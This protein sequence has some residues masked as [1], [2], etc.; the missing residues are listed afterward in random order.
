MVAIQWN[1]LSPS[2]NA[3]T[4]ESPDILCVCVWG[5]G[6]MLLVKVGR[7][8]CCGSDPHHECHQV[9]LQPLG[10]RVSI[11]L[12]RHRGV[13][14]LLGRGVCWGSNILRCHLSK[15]HRHTRQFE[16]WN[17]NWTCARVQ[18]KAQ[19]APW[20]HSALYMRMRMYKKMNIGKSLQHSVYSFFIN[21][22]WQV[23]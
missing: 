6:D 4:V 16:F 2:G 3:D 17:L 15:T 19:R 13:Y 7:T 12:V 11:L 10:H 23:A 9:L 22:L 8:W 14:A 18:Y 5:G 1:R 21:K 20:R